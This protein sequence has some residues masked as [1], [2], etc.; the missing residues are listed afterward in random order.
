MDMAE[1]FIIIL[2]I[3]IIGGAPTRK[4]NGA[5]AA[6]ISNPPPRIE[7]HPLYPPQSGPFGTGTRAP[8]TTQRPIPK[9]P[10]CKG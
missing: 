7:R 10:N 9:P 3:W 6:K 1:L 5:N 8:E 2:L 4:R